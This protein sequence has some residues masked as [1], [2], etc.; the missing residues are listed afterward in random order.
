VLFVTGIASAVVVGVGL[1]RIRHG[2]A[3]VQDKWNAVSIAIIPKWAWIADI[4]HAVVV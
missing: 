3:V 4:A 1:I 2:R